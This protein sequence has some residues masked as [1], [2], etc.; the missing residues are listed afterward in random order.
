MQVMRERLIEHL[1]LWFE[2]DYVSFENKFFA[3]MSEQ[4]QRSFLRRIMAIGIETISL[5]NAA[6]SGEENHA[7]TIHT[8]ALLDALADLDPDVKE[9]RL[10]NVALRKQSDVQA[11]S[12]IAVG[13]RDGTDGF[14]LYLRDIEC[15]I[16]Y[17]KQDENGPVGFLD[18]LFFAIPAIFEL[19]A[20]THPAHSSLVSPNAVRAML[21]N[22]DRHYQVIDFEY[23]ECSVSLCGLGLDDSHCLAIAD[24]LQTVDTPHLVHI[25]DLTGNP[26]ISARGYGALLSLINRTNVIFGSLRVDNKT[27]EAE[28]NLVIAMN[29]HGRLEYMMNGTFTSE[30]QRWQWLQKLASL[31]SMI[32]WVTD[33]KLVNFIWH[34]LLQHPEFMQA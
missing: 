7:I 22:V 3:A 9:L 21:L 5:G 23:S 13:E 16:D 19:S 30:R 26:K 14:S 11:L 1:Q 34:E 2:P 25:L 8:S 33:S 32:A 6:E 12:N 27:W 28:L 17:N 10:E 4:E 18:P 29:D 15:P 31:P 20:R 24:V